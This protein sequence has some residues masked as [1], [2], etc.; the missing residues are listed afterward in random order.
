MAFKQRN[1]ITSNDRASKNIKTLGGAID[2]SLHS[3]SYDEFQAARFITKRHRLAFPTAK[4]ICSLAW[5][6]GAM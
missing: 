2:T 5:I 1:P 4:L 3:L 6:G